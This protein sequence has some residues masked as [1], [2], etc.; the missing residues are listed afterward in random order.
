MGRP[1]THLRPVAGRP[2]SHGARA[3]ARTLRVNELDERT[4][5]AK[6]RQQKRN[7]LA[8]D[9][10][11]WDV[12][13]EAELLTISSAVDLDLVENAYASRVLRDI[14]SIARDGRSAACIRDYKGILDAKGRALVRLQELAGTRRARSN[15]PPSLEQYNAHRTAE[16]EAARRALSN[17]APSHAQYIAHRG[18]E[19]GDDAPSSSA[20]DGALSA[21]ELD[22]EEAPA[23]AALAK[24]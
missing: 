13:S 11:G 19:N 1:L 10:G 24:E 23:S 17:G 16:L 6:L 3:L 15:G 7:A 18:E 21:A 8:A 2:V 9:L 14:E 12:L 5:I 20:R 4:Q 22:P